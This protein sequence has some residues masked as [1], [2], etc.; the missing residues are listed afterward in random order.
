MVPEWAKKADQGPFSSLAYGN[1]E[2]K[3]ML[4]AA[5]VVTQRV[6]LTTSIFLAPIRNGG[7]LAKQAASL[8]AISGGRLT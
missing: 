3:T 1:Y 8:D 7:V 4:A 2:P 5:A 6:R